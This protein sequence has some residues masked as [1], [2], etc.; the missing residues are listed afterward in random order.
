MQGDGIYLN[1]AKMKTQS[2][3]RLKGRVRATLRNAI[4][5]SIIKEIEWSDN[6]I[7]AVAKT[8]ILNNMGAIGAKANEG[9]ITYGAVG[10][11]STTPASTDTQMNNEIGR[12]S[13]ASSVVN[14]GVLTIESFFNSAT[15]NGNLTQFALFGEDASGIANSGTMFQYVNFSTTI[16]KTSAETLTINSEVTIV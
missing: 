11:G 2:V 9:Q 13:I 5:G 4:D 12:A 1:G 14:S 3:L 7:V 8:A 16:T 6:I 10:D 15:G